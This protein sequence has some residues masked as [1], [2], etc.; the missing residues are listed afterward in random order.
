MKLGKSSDSSASTH[1]YRIVSEIQPVFDNLGEK[2]KEVNLEIFVVFR[3]LWDK[4]ERKTFRRFDKKE[5]VLYL[6]ITFSQD[7]YINM[8]EEEQRYDLSHTFFNYLTESLGKYKFP[9]L[10]I[11][12]FLQDLTTLCKEIGW[13]K[14]EWEVYI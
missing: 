11:Q 2:Y 3:C 1:V 9:G 6:D 13:L 4:L 10:P 8:T 12:D 7:K 14:E 5:N